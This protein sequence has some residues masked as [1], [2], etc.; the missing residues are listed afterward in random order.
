MHVCVI[1]PSPPANWMLTY[2]V[3]F[4]LVDVGRVFSG[5]YHVLQ[6]IHVLWLVE[7]LY[8]NCAQAI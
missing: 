5:V 1:P 2:G 8:I 3:S 4:L 7:R 6:Y